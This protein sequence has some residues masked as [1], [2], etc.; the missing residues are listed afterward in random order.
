MTF[1]ELI[2]DLSDICR[3]FQ[4]PLT[5]GTTYFMTLQTAQVN[6]YV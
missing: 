4:T 2:C 5:I 1:V 3:H 6:D